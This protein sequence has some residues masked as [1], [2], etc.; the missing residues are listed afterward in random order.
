MQTDPPPPQSAI[1]PCPRTV[2]QTRPIWRIPWALISIIRI[3]SSLNICFN[4][5]VYQIKYSVR[6]GSICLKTKQKNQYLLRFALKYSLP[7]TRVIFPICIGF[8]SCLFCFHLL[9]I[10]FVLHE[11]FLLWCKPNPLIFFFT[12]GT[13]AQD[14]RP[15]LFSIKRTPWAP[16][17]YPKIFLNS[18]TNSPRYLNLKFDWPLYNTAASQKNSKLGEFWNM[19]VIGLG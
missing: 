16:D 10:I 13:V 2:P 8:I 6:K 19:D 15:P 17:S 1:S 12:K 5:R 18:V 14:F 4:L 3:S 11:K 9:L 7:F